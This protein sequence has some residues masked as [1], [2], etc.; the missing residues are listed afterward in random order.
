MSSIVQRRCVRANFSLKVGSKLSRQDLSVLRPATPGA[1]RPNEIDQI[2]G[3]VLK[4]DL[5]AGQ[6]LRWSDIEKG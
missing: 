2:I 3:R 5:K 1:I 4:V 6:E